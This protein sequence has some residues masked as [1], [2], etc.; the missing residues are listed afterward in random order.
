MLYYSDGRRGGFRWSEAS[1]GGRIVVK[2]KKPLV[3]CLVAFLIIF[4][5]IQLFRSTG[6]ADVGKA[7]PHFTLADM[8]GR[9]VSLD[10]YRGEIVILDFW[11]TWC[12]PCRMTMPILDEIQKE[13]AGKMTVLAINLQE[14]KGVVREYILRQG[15]SAKVLLDEDGSVDRQYGIVA[16]P[17]QYLVDQKGIIRLILNG[18]HPRMGSQI[19]DEINK[20]L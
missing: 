12:G 18:F 3:I 9:E 1:Y 6:P 19:R 16:I 2:S 20:L 8:S 14:P 7:A 13:Y 17:M 4:V 15:L 10:D 5:A 11:A